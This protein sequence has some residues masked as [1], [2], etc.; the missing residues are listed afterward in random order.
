MD[1]MNYELRDITHPKLYCYDDEVSEL[2]VQFRGFDTS[3][4]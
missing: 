3:S 4:S 2:A 1:G